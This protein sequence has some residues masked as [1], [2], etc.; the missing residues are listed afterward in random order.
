MKKII[1]SISLTFI[2]LFASSQNNVNLILNHQFNGTSFVYNDVYSDENGNA[3]SFDRIQI[4]MSG[5]EL[6]HDGGQTTD[7]T[8]VYVLTHANV[9]NYPLGSFDVSNLENINF[10]LGVDYNANHGNSSNWSFTHP[11][12][13]QSP[14]MDWGWPSGYFFI[15]LDG[16]IDDNGDGVPNKMFQLR[17]L[18]DQMLRNV[19]V[20]VNSSNNGTVDINLDVNVEGWIKN[21]N[22]ATVGF[23]HSSS[24]NNTTV[25]NN[26][27]TYNVFGNHINSIGE[28]NTKHYISVDYS[29]TYAPILNYTLEK[30]N[31][32]LLITDINGKVIVEENN[33]G[34]EGSYF[35]KQELKSGIY[36]A[37]FT[38][39]K[40]TIT[41]KFVV[42]R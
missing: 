9:S 20:D 42:Q 34:F 27:N 21:L 32:K 35:I 11:L 3:V 5:I 41:E 33:I 40:E 1:F 8:G 39:N 10:N 36:F 38:N 37:I 18:G 19:D 25:C 26:T 17:S 6:T 16:K 24:S 4:Y 13:P 22:L 14:L 30:T 7:L 28:I 29:M 31:N 12:S 15:V 2:S 23:D